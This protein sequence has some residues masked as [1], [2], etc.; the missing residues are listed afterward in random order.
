MKGQNQGEYNKYEFLRTDYLAFELLSP[1]HFQTPRFK[2]EYNRSLA[3][4]WDASLTLGYGNAHLAPSYVKDEDNYRLFEIRHAWKF[5][6]I[7]KGSFRYF[8][9]LEG[10]YILHKDTYHDSYI[11]FNDEIGDLFFKQ[12]DFQREKL[13]VLAKSSFHFMLGNRLGLILYG[14]LGV[15]VRNNKFSNVVPLSLSMEE[16]EDEFGF[17]VK[18]NQ[19]EG[20]QFSGDFTA[21]VRVSYVLKFR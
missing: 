12:A 3:R 20:K 1:I 8:L 7:R 14:G 2:L 19:E 21:G 13:G 11:Y 10:F 9:S 6:L 5:Q 15:R 18:Y 4:R 16:F 17:N